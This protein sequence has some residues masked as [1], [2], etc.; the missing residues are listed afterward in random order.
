MRKIVTVVTNSKELT[1]EALL[2]LQPALAARQPG[3]WCQ[4]AW[5][6]SYSGQLRQCRVLLY[7]GGGEHLTI[8]WIEVWIPGWQTLT[9]PRP[10]FTTFP[11]KQFMSELQELQWGGGVSLPVCPLQKKLRS[12][13]CGLISCTSSQTETVKNIPLQGLGGGH[14]RYTNYSQCP[15]SECWDMMSPGPAL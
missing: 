9:L 12:Q 7:C 11:R 13:V 1:K 14:L 3:M 4:G 2:I 15:H 8:Y 5:A 10:T 6:V